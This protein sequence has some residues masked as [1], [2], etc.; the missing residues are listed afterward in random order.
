MDLN[1]VLSLIGIVS[2]FIVTAVWISTLSA[3]SSNRV[4]LLEVKVSGHEARMGKLENATSYASIEQ[5]VS[6][7][8]LQVLHSGEFKASMKE[9]LES[10]IAKSV[11]DTL[12]HIDRN[13][14]T[15]QAG[16]FD[17][18]L[19]TLKCMRAEILDPNKKEAHD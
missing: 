4:V 2:P 3:R 9:S 15:G 8:C 19:K 18:I 1:T 11:K 5:M 7:V 6:K 17:E 14:S 16:A 12:L 13:K 10:T